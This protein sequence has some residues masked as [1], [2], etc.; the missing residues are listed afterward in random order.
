AAWTTTIAYITAS[1]FYQISTFAQ[2]PLFS[3]LWLGGI[4]ILMI[5]LIYG[6]RQWAHKGT[7]KTPD[8]T[9]VGA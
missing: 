9:E 3:G 7:E 4:V 2:H 6:L 8:A 1:S 5:G